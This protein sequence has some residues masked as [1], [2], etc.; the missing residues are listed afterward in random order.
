MALRIV[1]D[2]IVIIVTWRKTYHTVRLARQS[3]TR[4]P[5]SEILL[6]EGGLFGTCFTSEA[7]TDCTATGLI[8][9]G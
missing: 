2:A 7:L 8:Y 6:R 9:F 4:T 1:A 5:M 3:G